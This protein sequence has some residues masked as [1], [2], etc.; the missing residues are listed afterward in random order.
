MMV[1]ELLWLVLR[2]LVTLVLPLLL[3]LSGQV[4]LLLLWLSWLALLML[5]LLPTPS[6]RTRAL[7]SRIVVPCRAASNRQSVSNSFLQPPRV[8]KPGDVCSMGYGLHSKGSDRGTERLDGPTDFLSFT[9]I[10]RIPPGPGLSFKEACSK[11]T[12]A[13]LNT[14]R[15]CSTLLVGFPTSF[16]RKRNDQRVSGSCDRDSPSLIKHRITNRSSLLELIH[17]SPALGIILPSL[18]EIKWVL[19]GKSFP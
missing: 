15:I 16:S 2:V 13:S 1:L 6:T 8:H 10:P 7:I 18:A 12:A 11:T 3:Y 17:S 19:Y 5:M 9:T 14:N 4:R